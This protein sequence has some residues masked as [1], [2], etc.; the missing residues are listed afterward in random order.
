MFYLKKLIS[1]KEKEKEQSEGKSGR[2]STDN[3]S[4]PPSVK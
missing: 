2:S 1:V 3:I 4:R